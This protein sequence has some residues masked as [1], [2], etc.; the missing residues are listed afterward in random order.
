MSPSWAS[1]SFIG[2]DTAI[3]DEDICADTKELEIKKKSSDMIRQILGFMV[4]SFV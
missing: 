2:V 3:P 1:V 4:A